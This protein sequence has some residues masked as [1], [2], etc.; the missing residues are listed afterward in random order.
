MGYLKV[1]NWIIIY[2]V[3]ILQVQVNKKLMNKV[4]HHLSSNQIMILPVN[5]N[6]KNH[7]FKQKKHQLCHFKRKYKIKFKLTYLNIKSTV[8]KCCMNQLITYYNQINKRPKIN[9]FNNK[10]MRFQ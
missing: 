7:K 1:I 3:Y 6:S 5:Q 4:K 2:K 8:K 10:V 9:K